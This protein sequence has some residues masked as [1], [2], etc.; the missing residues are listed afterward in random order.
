M[1]AT[2][3]SEVT[4]EKGSR[5][6]A[7]AIHH[8]AARLHARRVPVV[9]RLLD[10]LIFLLF[11]SVINHRTTIGAGTHCVYRGMSVLVH[12]RATVGRNVVLGAHVVI[13]GRS[14]HYEVP[15]IEDDVVIG[16]N[17]CILGNIRV[18]R[19]AVVGAGAVVIHDVPAGAVVVGTPARP[20]RA[21]A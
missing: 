5:L 4:A 17:A 15:V 9:P 14:S 20:I 1:D 2:R 11:N 12:E 21:S 13:G 7:V 19:G 3:A 18:G 10:G 6:D 8:L 16:A